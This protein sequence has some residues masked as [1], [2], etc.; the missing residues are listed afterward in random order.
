MKSNKFSGERK[1][2]V[3][4]NSSE[5]G[6]SWRG[7]AIKE[8]LFR[9]MEEL[10]SAGKEEPFNFFVVEDNNVVTEVLRGED[11]SG[12]ALE[13]ANSPSIWGKINT[14]RFDAKVFQPFTNIADVGTLTLDEHK[15]IVTTRCN[16]DF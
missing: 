11:L 6:A 2:V 12:L 16:N 7:K 1:L 4:S 14:L 13:S 15:E 10:Q 8:G 3:V 5:L 9:W